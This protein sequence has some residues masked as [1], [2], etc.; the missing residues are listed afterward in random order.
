MVMLRVAPRVSRF[1]N[2]AV[3]TTPVFESIAKFPPSLLNRLYVTVFVVESAS[4]ADAVTPTAVP[5]ATFSS[6]A[7]LAESASAGIVTANSLASTIAIEKA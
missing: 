3:V 7:S 2:A 6:T 4:L 5:I 1:N